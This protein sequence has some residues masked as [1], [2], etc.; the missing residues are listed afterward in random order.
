M[1]LPKESLYTLEDIYNLPEGKRAELIDGQIYAMAPP[2]TQHQRISA[3][4]FTQIMQYID[5]NGGN[6]E[7]FSAPFAVFLC[8]DES[9]YVEPDIS[10]ICDPDKITDQG[11][12]G[13]PDWIIEIVSPGSR[14]MDYYRKLNLYSIAGV[15][16]Y[17]IV[18]PMR[19]IILVYDMEHDESPVAY[20]FT[21][22]VPVGIYP[23]F[24]LDFGRIQS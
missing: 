13:A 11:C 16:E 3:R 12:S 1:P 5:Q 2:G 21:D 10:V 15:R 9:N 20:S 14:R 8:K 7:A 4:L 19:Q 24:T 17:W 6:C 23:G 22:S 18:D